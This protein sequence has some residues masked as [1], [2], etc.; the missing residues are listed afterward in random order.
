MRERP[1]EVVS[2]LGLVIVISATAVSALAEPPETN[3][4]TCPLTPMFV[5]PVHT[6]VSCPIAK[7]RP[8]MTSSPCPSV[9]FTL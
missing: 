7:V 6:L 5:Q 9:N 4:C 8:P 2:L 3:V 1:T